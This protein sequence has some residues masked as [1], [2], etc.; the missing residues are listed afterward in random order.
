MSSD[1]PEEGIRFCYGWLWATMWLL[2]FE[3]RTFGRA[4]GCSYPLSHLT[5]PLDVL[6]KVCINIKGLAQWL[7]ASLEYTGPRLGPQHL[8]KIKW[9]SK[10]HGEWHVPVSSAPFLKLLR[11]ARTSV[12]HTLPKFSSH[13]QYLMTWKSMLNNEVIWLSIP[14]SY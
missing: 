4:V 6:F 3:L 12:Y 8:N 14:P 2:G 5:S 10:S 1:T 7:N 13:G 11:C 9:Q